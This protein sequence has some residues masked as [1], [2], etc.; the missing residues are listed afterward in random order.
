MSNKSI[1]DKWK[2]RKKKEAEDDKISRLPKDATVPV[3]KSQQRLWFLQ[4]LYPD[5]PFYNYS[6]YH[7]LKGPLEVSCLKKSMDLIFSANDILRSNYELKEGQVMM[8]VASEQ[9]IPL[10]FMDL[11]DLGANEARNRAKDIMYTDANTAFD[12]TK[13]PLYRFILMRL[14]DNEHLLFLH[15]HHIIIDEWSMGI[16]RKQLGSNYAS[17]VSGKPG[18]VDFPEI[19]YPEYAHWENQKALNEEHLNYWKQR[20]DGNVPVLNL[21][22]DFKKPSQISFAGK[23]HEHTLSEKLSEDV[24]KL[25]EKL[26]VTPYNMLLCVFFIFLHRYTEQ[27]DFAVGS[28]ISKRGHKGLEGLIGF[29]IDTLVLRI[30]IEPETTFT[31]LLDT[32]RKTT[33]EAFA[34]SEISFNDLVKALKP[35]RVLSSNPFFNVMFVYNAPTVPLTYGSQ[36]DAHCQIH[37]AAVSKFDLT[38]FL[39]M[40]H[41]KM[42]TAFEYSTE[43]FKENTI[44]RFQEHFEILLHQLVK[45]PNA[46]ISK[47]NMLTV[48]EENLFFPEAVRAPRSFDYPKGIHE[49][50]LENAK[51]KGHETAVVYGNESISYQTLQLKAER[52]AERILQ[53]SK[54]ENEIIGLYANRSIE[55]IV[56]LIGILR[57]GCA[58]MP[59]DPDYPSQ[60]IDFMIR[61][62]KVKLMVTQNPLKSF[63]GKFEGALLLL[64]EEPDLSPS[65]GKSVDFPEVTGNDRA[66]VIYTS[67]STGNPKGVPITHANI[68]NSTRGR[69]DFY[70]NGPEAFLL[71]SSISFD[72]SKAGIFWTLCTGGKLIISEKHLEQDIERLGNTI[73]EHKISHT[74]MLPSLYG[75]ILDY[76][77]KIHLK[78]L[79]TVILAGEA[80][81][82][83]VC[84][85]HFEKLHHADL[86][87]E[88][89]P[90]EAT[91]WCL[92]H[93]IEPMD[94][95]ETIPIGKPV[96]QAQIFLLNKNLN[97]VPIG[98]VGE[99]YIGG[100]GLSSGYL[101]N[102]ELSSNA[103]IEN[104][105]QKGER[106]YR[107]G[108]LGKYTDEGQMVFMGRADQQIK[109][110]GHR[111]E[112]DEIEQV[113]DKSGLV[114]KA[115]VTLEEDSPSPELEDLDISNLENYM[116]RY[117]T[118]SEIEDLLKYVEDL[119]EK[120]KSYLLNQLS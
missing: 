110:R 94:I 22:Y 38:L 62:A 87:N 93:K 61:D 4:Q 6:E 99:I 14:A 36:I 106:L 47:L 37:G 12:L 64:D 89:G 116:E 19:Q 81:A 11:S 112:L 109:I 68:I 86:Y 2:N 48:Q 80:C 113:M 69:M 82:P 8:Q 46:T 117:L 40:D 54:G 10:R 56:G 74:L 66:Y 107:T 120:Q 75:A 55:M 45:D 96:A 108:D 111:V 13:G 71:M 103:F 27:I 105:F 41:G 49:I 95:D 92:A 63:L 33:L 119:D 44:R 18:A 104:P 1:L 88:Y 115:V 29:F 24:L 76:S 51:N 70:K 15:F 118:T 58:Y 43:L 101:N 5:N 57:A 26:S 25:A 77:E 67:G 91:V 20:L 98:V 85:N 30:Q 90:T 21:P 97:K 28:P 31:E 9:Q 114:S 102:Q 72:S 78:S 35:K 52:V 17:L 53:V 79:Q 59:I 73:A 60:R 7:T 84:K 3:S 65:D 23:T 83:S 42:T 34:N 32:V 39:G 50:I 16:F 100:P